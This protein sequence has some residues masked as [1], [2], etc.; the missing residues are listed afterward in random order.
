MFYKFWEFMIFENRIK[1]LIT[2][3]VRV[4][5]KDREKS[6]NKVLE[7]HTVHE[8]NNFICDKNLKNYSINYF[9][10]LGSLEEEDSINVLAN[11]AVNAIT[12]N[13]G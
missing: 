4:T 6:G 1:I 3:L 12:I 10:G 9:K 5:P 7:F 11:L 2:P 8:Y 13:F